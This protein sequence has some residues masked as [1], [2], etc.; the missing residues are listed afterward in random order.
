KNKKNEIEF[1]TS[2]NNIYENL[3]NNIRTKLEINGNSVHFLESSSH[4]FSGEGDTMVMSKFSRHLIV[5]SYCGGDEV[6]FKNLLT[7]KSV[8]AAFECILIDMSVYSLGGRLMRCVNQSKPNERRILLNCTE[9]SFPIDH[10]ILN[11]NINVEALPLCISTPSLPQSSPQSSQQIVRRI[12]DSIECSFIRIYKVTR[13]CKGKIEARYKGGCPYKRD[14]HLQNNQYIVVTPEKIYIHCYDAECSNKEQLWMSTKSIIDES[15]IESLPWYLHI[16]IYIGVSALSCHESNTYQCD[17]TNEL[18]SPIKAKL[19]SEATDYRHVLSPVSHCLLLTSNPAQS[20][21]VDVT[22]NFM[23]CIVPQMN[24][25]N[26]I[27]IDKYYESSSLDTRNKKKVIV[28]C[29]NI[30]MQLSSYTCLQRDRITEYLKTRTQDKLVK[31]WSEFNE[32]TYVYS[33]GI[34]YNYD[35]SKH[36]IILIKVKHTYIA[37]TNIN[38]LYAAYIGS[39]NTIFN[40][41]L[42][43]ATINNASDSCINLLVTICNQ[44]D[45][46]SSKQLLLYKLINENHIDD[47]DKLLD[48][49]IS[50]IPFANQYYSI[51]S[52]TFNDY[53]PEIYIT[54]TLDYSMDS[55]DIQDDSISEPVMSLLTQILPDDIVRTFVIHVLSAALYP[56]DPPRHIYFM[57]GRVNTETLNAPSPALLSVKGKRLVVNPETNEALYASSTIKRLCG[58]DPMTARDLYSSNVQ[59]FIIKARVLLSGNELPK[60]DTFDTAIRDRLVVIP[61]ERRFVQ[62]PKHKNESK[63]Q[64][65]LIYCRGLMRALILNLRNSPHQL[66]L[67]IPNRLL[68]L[69]SL[70]EPAEPNQLETWFR[71][72][73]EYMPSAGHV[74]PLATIYLSHCE[75]TIDTYSRNKFAKSLSNFI[76]LYHTEYPQSTYDT[77]RVG[78]AR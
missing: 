58:G 30:I 63:V 17:A 52:L 14:V 73:I 51:S 70:Q 16:Y 4:C 48:S 12:C 32:V 36:Y 77:H 57:Y 15:I 49:D 71:T 33:N 19:T 18:R 46:V 56:L 43:I 44:V 75:S 69:Q 62:N 11:P 31:V 23:Q 25:K 50:I 20:V 72:N 78:S 1:S 66:L 13:V 64:T 28:E 37:N 45:N 6:F 5:K 34:Y 40:D 22:S 26:C 41:I 65:D 60:F 74:L 24:I 67:I 10:L 54:Q 55:L 2:C 42:E 38:E 29:C 27:K 76:A 47:F 3:K 8:V 68:S 53:T 61:F 9:G 35:L 39:L 59:S 21:T 7:L